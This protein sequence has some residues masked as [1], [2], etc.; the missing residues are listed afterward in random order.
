MVISIEPDDRGFVG[1]E[2]PN[3]S[4]L[5]YFKIAPGTGDPSVTR[6]TCPY[7]GT[8]DENDQFFTPAQIEYAKSVVLNRITGAFLK[9]LKALERR[10]T[11]GA[12]LSIGIKVSG[13]A[14]PVAHYR[15]LALET[16]VVCETCTVRYAIY[17]VFGYCPDC[18]RH[19]S[20]QMLDTSLSVVERML[21]LAADAEPDLAEKLIENAL[22][23]CVSA[24]DGWGRA[25]AAAFAQQA[26]EPHQA[27][28]LS[29]QNFAR[30]RD[31]VHALFGF[32]FATVL[33]EDELQELNVVFQKRHLLAH[34]MG[35]I[36]ERYVAATGG[37]P[38]AIGRRVHNRPE[39][40]RR[41][42]ARLRTLASE[43]QA[44][45]QAPLP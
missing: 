36:D 44:H 5:G 32:D 38:A 21:D 43:L 40:V 8:C 9:E 19:N 16:E 15:E 22:E 24:F 31:R 11:R 42:V 39:D 27:Q 30:V 28:A 20:F 12:F 26:T 4:C 13:R 37:S 33:Q 2:C 25:T 45:F 3:E 41:T 10:P 35:V 14:H 18:R 29:F 7:C 34:K 17:G 1:R 23:D 6:C